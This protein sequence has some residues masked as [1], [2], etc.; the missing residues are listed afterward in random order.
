[1]IKNLILIL[2]LALSALSSIAWSQD[3]LTEVNPLP[4]EIILTTQGTSQ[5]QDQADGEGWYLQGEPVITKDKEI[6]LPPCYTDRTVTVSNGEGHGGQTYS[7]EC[8]KERSGTHSSDVT[9]TPPPA[10][11]KPGSNISFSMTCTS[12]FDDI[13]TSGLIG[14]TNVGTIVEGRSTNPQGNSTATYT[15]PN[16][17]PGDELELYANFVV[18]SGLHGD[19][20]YKY[21]Y[22]EAG[23]VETKQ[24][25]T[26]KRGQSD[27][28][29]KAIS[30]ER[31]WCKEAGYF[32]TDAEI[33]KIYSGTGKTL[34]YDRDQLVNM[35]ISAMEKYKDEGGSIDGGIINYYDSIALAASFYSGA[36]PTDREANL[37]KE[38]QEH[39]KKNGLLTPGDLFFVALSVCKGNV[40]DALVTSHAVLYRDGEGTNAQFIKDY[41]VPLRNPEAYNGA[42]RFIKS[43]K[44]KD[45][46]GNPKLQTPREV[47]GDDQQGV[48]YHLF[49]TA[50]IQ[51]Q[52]EVNVVP[53]AITRWTMEDGASLA[54]GLIPVPPHIS[55]MK[56]W[57]SKSEI[58][59]ELSNYALALE[60]LVRSS[61][62]SAADP[63]KQCIN[64]AGVAIGEALRKHIG[65]QSL[66]FG[67]SEPGQIIAGESLSLDR[68][69]TILGMSPVSFRI[70]G[71]NGEVFSLD[72]A[73][74]HFS[75]NTLLVILDPFM[76]DDGT[77]GLLATPLFEIKNIEIEAVE[78][79]NVTIGVYSYDD[80]KAAV[81]SVKVQTGD[82]YSVDL[83]QL[84]GQDKQL[85]IILNPSEKATK[86]E[87][88]EPKESKVIYDSWNKIVVQN[89]PTCSPIFTI[90]EPQMITYIDTYHWNNGKGTTSDGTI[91]LKNGDGETF[92]PWIV[93]PESAS[94]VANVWWI[95]HPNE[96]I[97]AGTYTIAD[98]DPETWS[99]NSESPCGFARVEG[100]ANTSSGDT[101]GYSSDLQT[102]KGLSG[103]SQE[104]SLDIGKEDIGEKDKAKEKP[105]SGSLSK[106]TEYGKVI[107][108]RGQAATGDFIWSP[109][110][111]AGFYYDLDS[112][113]GTEVLTAIVS[114]GKLSGRYPYGLTYQTT[115]QKKDFEFDSWGS[116]NVIGF[117][118]EKCFAGYLDSP[119]STDDR[120]FQESGDENV[121]SQK[122]LLNVLVDDDKEM[123]IT[124][125]RALQLEDGYVLSLDSVDVDGNQA[126]ITL[127]KDG[128]SLTTKKVSPSKD[129]ATMADKTF[130]YKKDIGNSKNVVIVAVHFKFA[131]RGADSAIATVDGEWQL[132]DT[133]FDVSKGTEYD[134]MTIQT[135]TSDTITIINKDNDITLGKNKD[136]SLMPGLGIKIEDD[137]SLRYYIYK[138]ITKPG[139]Y[140]IRGTV[141]TDTATWTADNFAGF[142][143]DIDDDIE[144]ERLTA[145]ITDGKL[146]EP[147]GVVYSTRTM[148][149]DFEFEDWGSYNVI[150]FLGEK[151]FAGYVEGSNSENGY[152][153][154]KSADK[155]ALAKGQ[156]LKVLVDDDTERTITSNIP[157]MLNDGYR[158]ELK[159]VNA[160][161]GRAYV[162]LFKDDKLID[163]KMFQPSK[164]NAA[165]SDKTYFY[166]NPQVGNQK[167]LVTIAVHFKNA[168][169]GTDQS[170]AT[171]DGVWQISDS[172]ISVHEGASFDKLVISTITSDRI[173]MENKDSPLTLSKNKDITL[174][175]DIHLRTA[176]FDSLRYYIAKRAEIEDTSAP[177]EAASL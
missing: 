139:I 135:V 160:Q 90:S 107:K 172:P 168:L 111:F 72:Q 101:I 78:N 87:N 31:P 158:L 74:K 112:D 115:V 92:G 37:K 110:N 162:E 12:P 3:T 21:K 32:Y 141:A 48:W 27:T 93:K 71:K 83:T 150:G 34:N 7:A 5:V 102:E 163:A 15:V 63:D 165:M 95:S 131:L 24:V 76:E 6:D 97:P 45:E 52:D 166:R 133:P 106:G 50:A 20:V 134:K 49:G 16:G 120:L 47:M 98:S 77:I 127:S 30:E 122:Q 155:S 121:L 44:E 51:F 147:D 151:C 81:R 129:G 153:F 8:F 75:G 164:E 2:L 128:T 123:T 1:M 175:G 33:E 84:I 126:T 105:E 138:E 96:V 69:V 56:G 70:E 59:T 19:V 22:Q 54:D 171:I 85:Q 39:Y 11:M 145:T 118:A 23:T 80:K 18:I 66:D 152:L 36:S 104:P 113:L 140:E 136:I 159:N 10:Y 64:Y 17:S 132:S 38:V 124:S 88:I 130:T 176:D 43:K 55:E 57:K 125:D 148:A 169:K 68:K 25:D 167:N 100:Y 114:S 9:W 157:L 65:K 58:G 177:K 108:L 46:N 60:N 99:K 14:A 144:T 41:L 73:D 67:I 119:E 53:W 154:D 173:S 146:E 62:G 149:N 170:I 161:D 29:A 61:G 82:S 174:A 35:M 143:Y 79:G 4:N 142:Y 91:S 137:D 156:L 86:T 26:G 103:S 94:G 116:Y 42:D 117:M 13:S 89:S 40:R 28:S 109:Q